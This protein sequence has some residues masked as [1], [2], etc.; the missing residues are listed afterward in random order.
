M[1]PLQPFPYNPHDKLLT[2]GLAASLLL[3]RFFKDLYVSSSRNDIIS[4]TIGPVS[5]YSKICSGYLMSETFFNN[6]SPM[7]KAILLV[8]SGGSYVIQYNLEED[9]WNG[10]SNDI[11]LQVKTF[12][13]VS[14][15][16]IAFTALHILIRNREVA[17]GRLYI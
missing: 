8:V 6:I 14:V 16:V 17:H 15:F 1:N 10:V 11:L 9:I 4:K 5:I 13:I 3:G 12:Y 2:F 7:R